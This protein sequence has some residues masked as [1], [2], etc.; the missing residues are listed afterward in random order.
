MVISLAN[1][2]GRGAV[3]STKT[4]IWKSSPKR[5]PRMMTTTTTRKKY[6]RRWG[7][8]EWRSVA[9]AALLHYRCLLWGGPINTIF[10]IEMSPP[11]SVHNVSLN[12]SI[13]KNKKSFDNSEEFSNQRWNPHCSNSHRLE[14]TKDWNQ[15]VIFR[16]DTKNHSCF[17]FLFNYWYV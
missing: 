9:G 16:D 11:L 13:F 5:L 2:L 17:I 3:R 12:W 7:R 4:P 14:L 1:S 10:A 15:S 8:D 6:W